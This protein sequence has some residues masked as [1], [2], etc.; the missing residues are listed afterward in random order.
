MSMMGKIL[1]IL[2]IL[3]M[4]GTLEGWQLSSDGNDF[5]CKYEDGLRAYDYNGTSFTNTAHVDTVVMLLMLP[6]DLMQ[7]DISYN[8]SEGLLAYTYN[9]HLP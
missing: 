6:F 3:M 8:E 9:V 5:P 7:H 2:P 4:E 1:T